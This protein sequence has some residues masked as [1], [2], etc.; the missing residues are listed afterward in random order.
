MKKQTPAPTT[1]APRAKPKKK[2][3]T[4]KQEV[5]KKDREVLAKMR[6]I[7]KGEACDSREEAFCQ[8]YASDVEFF[9]NGT[10]SYI[11]AY[12]VII[13]KRPDNDNSENLFLTIDAVRARA[14]EKLMKPHILKRIN[15]IFEA[16]GL[17]DTFVD[18]QLEK[19][20]VQDAD[21]SVKVKAIGEYN[22]LMSR[23]TENRNINHTILDD[24][25]TDEEIERE[26]EEAR[27]FFTK[28]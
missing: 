11:Q 16:H 28:Q 1:K 5:Q 21:L 6:K 13:G 20:I 15:E 7:I 4:R 2:R 3:A 17:N 19:L 26:I 14:Y 10:Q 8:Y 25:R 9:G 12:D 24:P 18:K 23:I 22:K 27:K